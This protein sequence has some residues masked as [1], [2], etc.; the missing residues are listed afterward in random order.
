M[1]S[2]ATKTTDSNE[3]PKT[4]VVKMD[5]VKTG[6]SF[7]INDIYYNSNS[8]ELTESS[9]KVLQEFAAYLKDNPK[10]VIEIQGHTDNVGSA[11]SNQALS[12]NRAFTVKA[13]LE[14]FGIHGDRV[15]AKGY[16]P[17]R[18]IADNS[19][20]AGRAKNRRTEFL[21]IENQ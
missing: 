1:A 14:S 4:I 2:V 21:I 16:G 15:K 3:L 7:V 5:S 6:A 18:P 10:M 12:A 17:S 11:T 20:E 19:S 9:K 8:A 13:T